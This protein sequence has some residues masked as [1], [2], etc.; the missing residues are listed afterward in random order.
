MK[1]KVEKLMV[2]TDGMS[3]SDR[4]LAEKWVGQYLHEGKYFYAPFFTS[5]NT[6]ENNRKSTLIGGFPFISKSHPWPLSPISSFSMQPILQIDMGV[7]GKLL[8]E[9]FETGILQ[10]WGCIAKSDD[11]SNMSSDDLLSIKYI[12]ASDLEADISE[13]FP[14]EAFWLKSQSELD[15]HSIEIAFP[16]MPKEWV[17]GKLVQWGSPQTMYPIPEMCSLEDTEDNATLFEDIFGGMDDEFITP[18]TAPDFYLGGLGGQAG[19]HEDPSSVNKLLVRL[20]N[21]DALHVGVTYH[22]NKK[23]AWVFQP[24]LRY[25]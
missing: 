19:G 15:G 10:L 22:R 4:E 11:F 5:L 12:P 17:D 13:V 7:A 24:F 25:H 3:V 20:F 18:E 8:G 2:S 16:F 23:G 9:N 1:T 6:N 14:E 21:G